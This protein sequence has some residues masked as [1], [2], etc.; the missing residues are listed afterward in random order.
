MGATCTGKFERFAEQIFGKDIKFI[1]EKN[2]HMHLENLSHEF[3]HCTTLDKTAPLLKLMAE[4]RNK[5]EGLLI[6]CNSIS[7]CQVDTSNNI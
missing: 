1:V 7:S 6:F 4:I 5:Y 2:S 3:I